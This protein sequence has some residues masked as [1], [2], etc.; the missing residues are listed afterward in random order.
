MLSP[1]LSIIVPAYNEA[2]RIVSSLEQ[3]TEFL[4]TR[5]Y[6]WEVVVVDDGSS[7][8]T[9]AL[10]AEFALRHPQVRLLERPHQGKGGAVKAGM[11]AATGQYRFMCDADL[12]M[13]IH[14]V[15]RFLPPQIEGVDVVVG[16]REAAGA[17]RVGE[18]WRRHLMGRFYNW[19]VR[20]LAV[21]GLQDTQCGFKCFRGEVA[22]DLFRRQTL[23]GFAFD[24]EVLFLARKAGL[25]IREAGIEWHYRQ[26]SRVHPLRDSAA[27]TRDLLKIRWRSLTGRYRRAE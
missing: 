10:V 14:Q 6:A 7:D 1:R 15:E 25:V 11:L 2:S 13:P 5:P 27:M 24:V 3:V 26:L 16:S 17:R 20:L 18:P 22:A 9:L 21:P 12:S 23:D 19:L 8:D 4:S